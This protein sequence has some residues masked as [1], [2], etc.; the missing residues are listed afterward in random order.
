MEQY[1]NEMEAYQGGFEDG[2]S[3]ILSLRNISP[4]DTNNDNDLQLVSYDI[5]NDGIDEYYLIFQYIRG[6]QYSD[7]TSDNENY[8]SNF[9]YDT[10]I[11][12]GAI[13]YYLDELEDHAYAI[14]EFQARYLYTTSDIEI[15]KY[16]NDVIF[17]T[18]QIYNDTPYVVFSFNY[19][20][21]FGGDYEGAT[22]LNEIYQAGFDAGDIA[23][24]TDEDIAFLEREL[25]DLA[26]GGDDGTDNT[27]TIGGY[28]FQDNPVDDRTE[29]DPN[30]QI[31]HYSS[32][33]S[34][35]LNGYYLTLE[36][37]YTA[38]KLEGIN[39][40]YLDLFLNNLSSPNTSQSGL[41]IIDYDVDGDGSIDQ[42]TERFLTFLYQENYIRIQIKTT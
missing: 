39:N 15:S 34:G 16:L 21:G 38:G 8:L 35:N 20:L 10:A 9:L 18:E 30:Y 31:F 40:T 36:E 5:N 29:G 23:I 2:Q 24:G 12:Q 32:E 41:E 33:Y 26:D 17:G 6:Y 1:A 28:N 7:I 27:Y 19:N 25:S 22:T 14:F 37:V 4:P 11:E 13:N 3:N 42:Q